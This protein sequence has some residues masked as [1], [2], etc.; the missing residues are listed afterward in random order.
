LASAKGR[1]LEFVRAVFREFYRRSASLINPPP[2]PEMR[3]YGYWPFDGEMVRHIA[4][5][6]ADEV[7]AA[8]ARA[9]PLHAYRSAA[10]YRYPAAPMNEKEWLGADLI[11]DIDADHLD[12]PC[13]GRHEYQL[14]STH[15]LVEEAGNGC[16]SCGQ[17]LRTL[18]WVCEGCISGARAEAARLVAILMD[19]LGAEEGE[20]EVGFSGNRGYHVVVYSEAFRGL[21][22]IAR[23]AIVSYLLCEGLVPSLVG[24]PGGA[25]KRG[26]PSVKGLP[27]PTFQLPGLKGRIER[28]IYALLQNPKL[29]P[30]KLLEKYGGII[31]QLSSSWIE[32]PDWAAAPAGLWAKLVEVAIRMESIKIDP[33][34][35]AD[36]HRLLRLSGTLNGKT[37]LLACRIPVGELEDTDPLEVSAA[38][39]KD[40]RVRVRVLY[41]PAFRLGGM[42]FDE[43]PEPRSMELPLY[44]ATYLILRGAA[45]LEGVSS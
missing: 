35:T 2:R 24:L 12:P 30:Q 37:G 25:G 13:A 9:S 32:E 11:F 8:V 26:R 7:R 16:P 45:E 43:V 15:G 44:A 18:E 6:S 1:S 22:Q 40:R 3:E 28:R 17:P 31:E 33:V 38:L 23:R 34:V 39:P 21:D 4:L 20:I 5:G 41:C 19:E 42:E 14:C 27:P 10:Y 29:L 36:I